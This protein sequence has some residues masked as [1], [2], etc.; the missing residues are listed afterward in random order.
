[1]RAGAA[2][3]EARQRHAI[4]GMA[5]HRPV[6]EQL[7]EPHLAVEDVAADQPEAALQIERRQAPSRPSTDAAKPGA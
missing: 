1:M 3:I 2:Q 4:I 6:R 7:V 5:Q